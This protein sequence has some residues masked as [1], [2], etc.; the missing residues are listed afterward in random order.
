MASLMT[1]AMLTFFSSAIF[2]SAALSSAARFRVISDLRS[3]RQRDGGLS[4]GGPSWQSILDHWTPWTIPKGQPTALFRDSENM[5]S[6][7]VLGC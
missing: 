7:V 5:G 1:Q 2:P 6:H 4:G 3:F